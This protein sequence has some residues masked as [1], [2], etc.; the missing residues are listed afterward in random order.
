MTDGI[1]LR[2]FQSDPFL[3]KYSVLI[4]D[5]AHERTLTTDLVLGLLKRVLAIR[6][7]LRVVVMSA[8][9]DAAVSRPGLLGQLQTFRDFF[10]SGDSPDAAVS[11]SVEGRMYPVHV[12][13]SKV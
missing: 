3:T 10:D 12:F 4:V 5:E 1:L 8:T 7:D 2:E 9:V 13:Y 6:L 11:I